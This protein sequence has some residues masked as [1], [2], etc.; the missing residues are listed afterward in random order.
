MMIMIMDF[1]KIKKFQSVNLKK[2]LL[3]VVV[4]SGGGGDNMVE[5][6]HL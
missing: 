1:R 4:A 6:L 3:V 5:N 2:K